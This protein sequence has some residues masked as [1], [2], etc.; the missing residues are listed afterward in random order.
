MFESDNY[1]D[2]IKMLNAIQSIKEENQYLSFQLQ[3]NDL[4]FDSVISS[5]GVSK[6]TQN[7]QN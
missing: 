7:F 4:V 6:V 3:F 1:Q 5:V 2:T